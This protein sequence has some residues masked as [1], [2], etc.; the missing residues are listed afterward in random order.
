MMLLPCVLLVDWHNWNRQQFV[1]S[2][3]APCRHHH[4]WQ[5]FCSAPLL[6]LLP[7][8]LSW[9]WGVFYSTHLSTLSASLD[10]HE[11]VEIC[12]DRLLQHAK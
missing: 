8:Y 7:Q 12:D 4:W 10:A 5:H 9:G 6:L 1:R 2:W 3:T 11:N